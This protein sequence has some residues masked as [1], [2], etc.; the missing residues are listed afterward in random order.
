M[1]P[2]VAGRPVACSV[3]VAWSPSSVSINVPDAVEWFSGASV[4]SYDC[5]AA[6]AGAADGYGAGGHRARR[7]Q[8]ETQILQFHSG[9]FQSNWGE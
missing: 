8:S 1:S 7:N 9:T 6:S 4:A 5:V 3:I 2:N